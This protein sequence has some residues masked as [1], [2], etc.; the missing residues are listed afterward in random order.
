MKKSA[1]RYQTNGL[2]E[3]MSFAEALESSMDSYE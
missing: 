1:Q 3:H 2:K